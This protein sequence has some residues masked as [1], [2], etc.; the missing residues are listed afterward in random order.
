LGKAGIGE[1]PGRQTGGGIIVIILSLT[2][3]EPWY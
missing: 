1:V 3:L 2:R